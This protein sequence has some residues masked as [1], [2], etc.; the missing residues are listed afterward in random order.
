MMSFNVVAVRSSAGG[1]CGKW[2][3]RGGLIPR[4]LS[5]RASDLSESAPT[6]YS[7][8]I[9]LDDRR[10]LGIGLDPDPPYLPESGAGSS[11]TRGIERRTAL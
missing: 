5:S 9:G 10:A 1:L 2:R 11:R 4:R 7:Q 3:G 8:K 6:A